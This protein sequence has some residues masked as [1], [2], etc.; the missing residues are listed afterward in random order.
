MV[1]TFDQLAEVLVTT[2][3]FVVIGLVFFAI[4]FFILDKTM[5][6]SVHK[7]IEE[8]QNTALGLIIGSMMLGIAII[9]AAAIHG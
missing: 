8:D 4:S 3:I 7:E 1:V 2:L 6:Y 5:P 9:I